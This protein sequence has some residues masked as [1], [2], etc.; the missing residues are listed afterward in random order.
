MIKGFRSPSDDIKN[1]VHFRSS[2]Y[3]APL[4]FDV[5]TIRNI[6]NTLDHSV[7]T[8]KITFSLSEQVK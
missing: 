7:T 8:G 4:C 6:S 1:H 3:K 2:L 5:L